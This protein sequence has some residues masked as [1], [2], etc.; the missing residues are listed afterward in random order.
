[1]KC[2]ICNK[3]FES[4]RSDAKYC[5]TKC[6]V[7]AGRVKS[8]SNTNI[9]PDTFKDVID[10]K[11]PPVVLEDI[12]EITNSYTVPNNMTKTDRLFWDSKPGYFKFSD[13]IHNRV[14][15][16]CGAKFKTKLQLLNFCSPEDQT[17][18]LDHLTGKH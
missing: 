18:F 13:E 3:D 15:I 7:A 11:I 5:S 12:V 16:M 6:R 9:P 10:S 4:V 1:M 17:M 8:V 14:C 2:I